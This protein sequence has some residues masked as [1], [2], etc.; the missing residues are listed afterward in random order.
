LR[1]CAF[2]LIANFCPVFGGF[3]ISDLQ[4]R[5]SALYV[6]DVHGE[7]GAFVIFDLK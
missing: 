4:R 3:S 7:H 1:R 5:E 2:W 6:L